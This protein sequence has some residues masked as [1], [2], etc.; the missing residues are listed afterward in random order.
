[1]Q[2]ARISLVLVGAPWVPNPPAVPKQARLDAIASTVIRLTAWTSVDDETVQA[3][4]CWLFGDEAAFV[5]GT[6]RG[7]SGEAARCLARCSP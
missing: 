1:M 3:V 7:G 6:E 5:A 4:Y 2:F